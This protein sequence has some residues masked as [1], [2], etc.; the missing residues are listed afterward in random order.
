MIIKRKRRKILK[1]KIIYSRKK[2]DI[3]KCK[4]MCVRESSSRSAKGFCD[5][6]EIQDKGI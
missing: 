2:H 5:R 3:K 4:C 1:T 6:V